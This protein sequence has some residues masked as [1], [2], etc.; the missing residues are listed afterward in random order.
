MNQIEFEDRVCCIFM[1][2][3]SEFSF[4]VAKVVKSDPLYYPV[5]YFSPK[6]ALEVF[7]DLRSGPEVGMLIGNQEGE[8]YSFHTYIQLIDNSAACAFGSAIAT[9]DEEIVEL[10]EM[11]SQALLHLGRPLLLGSD[12]EFARLRMAEEEGCGLLPYLPSGTRFTG[13]H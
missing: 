4:Q 1:F 9:K 11:F 12:E 3:K 7:L 2:L 10:L 6:V 5:T 8:S 13:K